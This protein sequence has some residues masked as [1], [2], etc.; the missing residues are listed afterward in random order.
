MPVIT[1]REGRDW[2]A[3]RWISERVFARALERLSMEDRRFALEQGRALDGLFL[4]QLDRVVADELRMALCEAAN[5][6]QLDGHVSG[7]RD[8]EPSDLDELRTSVRKL[9]EVLREAPPA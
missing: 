7:L 9:C 2:F 6:L 4:D 5:S 3:P 1:S 8:L